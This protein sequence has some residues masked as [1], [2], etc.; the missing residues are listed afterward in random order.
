MRAGG[1]AESESMH[2]QSGWK[3]KETEKEKEKEKGE[4]GGR[5]KRCAP[6]ATTRSQK[7]F[8]AAV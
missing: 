7:P 1:E 2:G 3:T 6:N 4:G 5:L 8:K